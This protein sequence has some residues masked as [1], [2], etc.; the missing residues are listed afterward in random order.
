M[1]KVVGHSNIVVGLEIANED[2]LLDVNERQSRHP[3]LD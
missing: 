3:I 2:I 1:D